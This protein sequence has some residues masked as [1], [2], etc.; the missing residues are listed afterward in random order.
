MH[1]MTNEAVLH[2]R[3]F[4]V[5]LGASSPLSSPAGSVK[6]FLPPALRSQR[7]QAPP[8]SR[9]RTLG[10][11]P[12]E[13]DPPA[14]DSQER[15]RRRPSWA[16]GASDRPG[17]A[18]GAPRLHES[19]A[20]TQGHPADAGKQQRKPAR[21][22]AGTHRKAGHP[23]LT[24]EPGGGNGRLRCELTFARTEACGGVPPRCLQE[25]AGRR[26]EMPSPLSRPG[27]ASPASPR[28]R[29]AAQGLPRA[30][31]RRAEQPPGPSPPT[32]GR[33][34]RPRHTMFSRPCRGHF[35]SHLHCK[36]LT[37]LPKH[38]RK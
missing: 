1:G 18:C 20:G 17:R 24:S 14:A 7:A 5:P 36:Q 19:R 8:S 26:K 23:P 13:G 12:P 16:R 3:A 37:F 33:D 38:S 32:A 28:P 2:R 11:L 34:F 10:V 27:G 22:P 25:V 30:W 6:P 35:W 9:L 29:A 4:P 15:A 31:R 21:K